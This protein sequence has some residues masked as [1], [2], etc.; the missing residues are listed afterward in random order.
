MR[1]INL[2]DK[3]SNPAILF[4]GIIA[5]IIGVGV[6][7]FVFTSL[8]PPMLENYLTISFAGVLASINYVGYLAGSIFAVFIKDI[9]AKVKFWLVKD[10]MIVRVACRNA[11]Q[12]AMV[13]IDY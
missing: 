1:T 12:G 8:L 10:S 11:C 5:L 4:A 7:R 2:L 6:A 3:N 9:N 13:H